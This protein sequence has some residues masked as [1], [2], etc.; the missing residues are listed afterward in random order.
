VSASFFRFSRRKSQFGFTS[1]KSVSAAIFSSFL[2]LDPV[3]DGGRGI[4]SLYGILISALV[5]FFVFG[6]FSVR[7]RLKLKRGC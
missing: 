6:S 7:F 3:V 2:A 5:I 1:T 4:A